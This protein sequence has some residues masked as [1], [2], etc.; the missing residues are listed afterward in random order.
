MMT[1]ILLIDDDEKLGEL[2]AT[3]CI[4]ALSSPIAPMHK[5]L[6]H[7]VAYPAAGLDCASTAN[8]SRFLTLECG[9][10]LKFLCDA[11]KKLRGSADPADRMG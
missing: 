3:L 2:L 11:K 9:Q 1:K 5:V 7:I 4:G 10:E 6:S 8:R